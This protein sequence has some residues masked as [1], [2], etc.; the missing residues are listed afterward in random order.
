MSVM[1]VLPKGKH[2][3]T[4]IFSHGLGDSAAG[5]Y[6]FAQALAPRFKHVKWVL[7]TAPTQPVTLNG[8][9]PMNSWFDIRSLTPTNSSQ[10]DERGLLASVRTISDLVASEVD[11]GIPANR[12]VVGGFSQGAVVSLAVGATLERKLAGLIS[13]SG[14]LM[15]ADK[16]KSMQVDHAPSYPVFWGHGTGDPVVRYQWG[17]M[18]VQK[19]RELGWK[20]IQFESYPVTTTTPKKSTPAPRN[21]LPALA[22]VLRR[23]TRPPVDLYCYYLFLQREGSEDT[24]D[25][26]LDVQ[27]HEN[28]CRAYF[29][30]L[31]KSGRTVREDWPRYHELARTRGSIYGGVTGIRRGDDGGEGVEEVPGNTAPAS[32]RPSVSGRPQAFSGSDYGETRVTKEKAD[33]DRRGPSLGGERED[34]LR[35]PSPRPRTPASASYPLSPTLQALYPHDSEDRPRNGRLAAP[36]QPYI[37]RDT[38]ISRTDLI[39]SAER[40]YSRYLM[41]GAD[42]EVYLPPALRITEFTLSSSN[43]PTVTHPDYDR[44][45]DAQAQVPDM[46]HAQK[47]YVYRAMEQDT[48]PRF[49][50]AKAFGNLTP[51]SALVRLAFG[52][53][54]LWVGLATGFAFIFLDKKPKVSRLWVIIPFTFAII[55]LVAHAYDL[56]PLLVFM[57]LSET[58]PFRTIGIR[59]PYVRKL[60]FGR[61]L[62]VTFLSAVVVAILTIIFVLVPGHRL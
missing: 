34:A 60:L 10:E 46:F 45:A 53:L 55:N 11:A 41:P 44:E 56:D 20:N 1:T 33:G 16:L 40:I 12:I 51:I 50:R 23:N 4:I 13:L 3:A 32:P 43:L 21:R 19:L 37:M 22:E 59:E 61:A 57:G 29:K 35:T 48:F 58:T 42:K 24:L 27:Q 47:E 28:L 17:E 31:R 14:F 54:A 52:L 2:T 26:W 38:A 7:P 39:A 49:L 8:G 62:W 9:M 30:D 5:W 36:A 25:F 6:P 15:L 18:S